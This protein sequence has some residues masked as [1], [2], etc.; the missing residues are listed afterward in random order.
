MYILYW[1]VDVDCRQQVHKQFNLHLDRPPNNPYLIHNLFSL[2]K[3]YCSNYL[4][5]N[6][7]HPS[8]LYLPERIFACIIGLFV[9]YGLNLPAREVVVEIWSQGESPEHV[10]NAS[11]RTLYLW[12]NIHY[13]YT[14]LENVK[15]GAK[16]FIVFQI[17]HKWHQ[18]FL[19]LPWQTRPC[20][21]VSGFYFPH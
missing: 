5:Q 14:F 18:W 17:A 11:W 12:T 21:K 2:M 13:F 9:S 1:K 19:G 16:M 7:P 20:H 15:L 4:D 8:L 6:L 10:I 3:C